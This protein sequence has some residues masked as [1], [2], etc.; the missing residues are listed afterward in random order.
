MIQS[1]DPLLFVNPAKREAIRERITVLEEYLAGCGGDEAALAGAQKL[2]MRVSSF[3]RILKVWRDTRDPTLLGIGMSRRNKAI[4]VTARCTDAQIQTATEAAA[5]FLPDTVRERLVARAEELGEARGI[6]MPAR[7]KLRLLIDSVAPRSLRRG[8]PAL[9]SGTIVVDHVVLDLGVLF[10]G[11]H[12]AIKPLA[13]FLLDGDSGRV[14]G[15][16]LSEAPPGPSS[17]AALLH[18]ALLAGSIV[19]CPGAS[20]TTVRPL[21]VDQLGDFD[22]SDL[23][24]SLAAS[25]CRV[26]GERRRSA[27]R[28]WVRDWYGVSVAGVTLRPGLTDRA[29][30]ERRWY[31]ANSRHRPLSAQEAHDL[32]R[33][34]LLSQGTKHAP[35]IIANGN[36][37]GLFGRINH[38][39]LPI[40]RKKEGDSF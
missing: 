9:A 1:N 6:K 36:E 28:S 4:D 39:L 18:S 2:G 37:A 25:G 35:P 24:R 22:W 33:A 31:P 10:S 32:L 14:L 27:R 5:E 23:L 17:V 7:Q 38:A 16:T 20:A 29:P 26:E 11:R 34:R 21:L 8:V 13:S 40:R 3:N 19:T 30:A 15:V 12:D